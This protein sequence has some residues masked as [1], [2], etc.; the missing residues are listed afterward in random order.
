MGEAKRRGHVIGEEVVKRLSIVRRLYEQ[1][2]TMYREKVKQIEGRIVSL[3]KPQVRPI[4]RGKEWKKVEFGPKV[5]LSHV[6][7]FT[8]LDHMSHDNFN[9]VKW[10]SRQI[11][12]FVERFGTRPEWCV[13]DNLYGSRENRGYLKGL[14]IRDSFVPLGRREKMRVV[15]T[16][17]RRARR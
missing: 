11:E 16:R 2:R 9:E 17:L 15:N 13:G 6:N 12:H 3:H 5:A 7:G 14:G 8:F 4:V 10:L 1:Q